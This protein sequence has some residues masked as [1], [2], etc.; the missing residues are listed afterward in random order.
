M[1]FAG[2]AFEAM[3]AAIGELKPGARDQILHRARN[4][5]LIGLRERCHPSTDVHRE[6]DDIAALQLAFAGMKSGAHLQ[7]EGVH[8]IANRAGASNRARGTMRMERANRQYDA[9]INWITI[10]ALAT[11]VYVA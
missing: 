1:P 6:P 11:S 9:V 8:A 3:R 5:H 4:H 2:D 7:P 10:N